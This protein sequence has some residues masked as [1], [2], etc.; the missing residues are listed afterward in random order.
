[1]GSNAFNGFLTT[2]SRTV[3]HDPKNT[4]SGFVGLAPHHLGDEPISGS[5]AVFLFTVSEALGTMDVP[6]RQTGASA[7]PEILMFDPHG[8]AGGSR[9]LVCLRRRT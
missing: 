2:V 1:M 4:L 8:S 6:S 5:N 7:F 3:I 9:Q